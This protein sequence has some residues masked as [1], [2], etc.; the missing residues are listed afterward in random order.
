MEGSLSKETLSVERREDDKPMILR[1]DF[2][3]EPLSAPLSA[4]GLGKM[5]MARSL[6]EDL[7]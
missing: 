3:G 1:D 6:S 2:R 5:I 7:S 4:G